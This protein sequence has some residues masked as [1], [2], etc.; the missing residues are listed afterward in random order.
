[1][2]FYAVLAIGRIVVRVNIH[3]HHLL[4]RQIRKWLAK[5]RN[6]LTTEHKNFAHPWKA[7]KFPMRIA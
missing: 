6:A 7:M 1:M 3:L 5:R 4:H 2:A